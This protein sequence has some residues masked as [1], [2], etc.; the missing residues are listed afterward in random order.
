MAAKK[1]PSPVETDPTTDASLRALPA[2]YADP[3]DIP[4]TVQ[5]DEL[6]SLARLAKSQEARLSPLGLGAEVVDRLGRFAK[7]LGALE[8]RWQSAREGV[9]LTAAEQKLRSEAE[10]LDTKLVEAGRWGC[11]KDPKAL[12]ELARIAEGSG[13]A[14]TVQDLRDGVAFW[15]AHAGEMK[16]TD[17]TK[18]DL[19]RATAL[20]DKLEAAAAK[21][22]ADVDAASAL[23]LRNRCF[24][25]ANDLANEVRQ[26]GR[27]AFRA[28]PKV[29]AKF[30]SRHRA[31]AVRRSRRKAKAAAARPVQNGA[32][33]A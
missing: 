9:R 14:D 30:T 12:E 26:G 25:A 5:T 16:V 22:A 4:V 18:A 21:E 33:P 11:R 17:V 2:A 19:A 7:K 31:Q 8:S 15:E 23:E 3:P 1:K 10:A 6:K 32:S 28:E 29:A 20:A 27:Y 13:L 24:W